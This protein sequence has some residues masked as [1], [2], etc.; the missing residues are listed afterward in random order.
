MLIETRMSAPNALHIIAYTFSEREWMALEDVLIQSSIG[1]E[2][3]PLDRDEFGRDGRRYYATT[4][5]Q[6]ASLARV[7]QGRF[8]SRGRFEA[9]R[10]TG[11]PYACREVRHSGMGNGCEEFEAPDDSTAIVRCGI[12]A[13][14]KKWFGGDAKQ[15]RCGQ[16]GFFG[17]VFR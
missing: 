6:I 13:G 2:Y 14:Q 8:D 1:A 3:S 11:K 4:A 9:D 15:G 10:A 12:I 5:Q 7:L 17:R 16:R